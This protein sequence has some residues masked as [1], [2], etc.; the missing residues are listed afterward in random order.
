LCVHVVIL[1]YKFDTTHDRGFSKNIIANFGLNHSIL[2]FNFNIL[3]LNVI[4][5]QFKI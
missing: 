4:L 1:S 2:K 5:F 3:Y